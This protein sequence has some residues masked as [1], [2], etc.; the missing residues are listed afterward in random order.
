MPKLSD[1][2]RAQGVWVDNYG[3]HPAV[4]LVGG[5][6]SVV[7]ICGTTKPKS[8]PD[9]VCIQPNSPAGYALGL[10]NPT[11]FYWW[12]VAVIVQD[13]AVKSAKKL[14]PPSVFHA[15]EKLAIVAAVRT[16]NA[17]LQSALASLAKVAAV[18][19]PSIAVLAV[20]Q[21]GNGGTTDG[22][23]GATE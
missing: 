1:L 13:S 15:L 21:S 18:Q 4:V 2:K 5:A 17:Q 23:G 9:E 14:C 16:K 3:T 10:S 19:P 8:D 6:T 7:V 20:A 22:D 12:K 11:Y